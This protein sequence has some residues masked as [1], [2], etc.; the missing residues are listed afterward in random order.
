[1]IGVALSGPGLSTHV[2]F[3]ISLL[4][5]L[6]SLQGMVCLLLAMADLPIGRTPENCKLASVAATKLLR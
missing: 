5:L 3:V 4:L 1:M 6:L 2:M